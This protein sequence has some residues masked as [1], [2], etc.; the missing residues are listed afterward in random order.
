VALSKGKTE[1]LFEPPSIA[2]PVQGSDMLLELSS[3]IGS[4]LKLVD[5]VLELA[6]MAAAA[7]AAR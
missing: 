1:D 3:D 6:P 5:A 2:D 4:V 7:P